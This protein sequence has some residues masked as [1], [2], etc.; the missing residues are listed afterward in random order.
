MNIQK[1]N[2]IKYIMTN[3]IKTKD[4]SLS[5]LPD[6]IFYKILKNNTP[7]ERF[8]MMMI[9]NKKIWNVLAD[10]ELLV[11]I[12]SKDIDF[13]MRILNTYGN[14]R[15]KCEENENCKIYYHT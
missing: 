2:Q 8:Q 5:I 15:Y 4:L 7:E 12:P 6:E 13:V 9:K 1:A 14:Y 11:D 3:N 10:Y